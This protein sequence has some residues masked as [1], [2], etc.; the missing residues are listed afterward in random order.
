MKKQLLLF[1]FLI[2]LSVTNI[3]SQQFNVGFKIDMI[4]YV[5]IEPIKSYAKGNSL[6]PFPAF[7]LKAGVLFFNDLELQLEGGSQIGDRFAGIEAAAF[8][9]LRAKDNVFAF[10][11]YLNH[12]NEGHEGTGDGTL[13]NTYNFIGLGAEIKASELFSAD[14]SY[15]IPVGRKVFDYTLE[16]DDTVYTTQVGSLVRLGFIF[17]FYP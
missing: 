11:S 15:Y 3:Y 6:F 16:P 13:T 4:K 12:Q 17:S 1:S 8:I 2:L 14:L 5:R 10:I 7:F 9:K